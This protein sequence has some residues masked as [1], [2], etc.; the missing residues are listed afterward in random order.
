MII[1]LIFLKLILLGKKISKLKKFF[2]ELQIM[3][4]LDSLSATIYSFLF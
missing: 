4:H 2:E 3:F 1:K